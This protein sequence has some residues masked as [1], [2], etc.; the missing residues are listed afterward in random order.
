MGL[1]ESALSW[2]GVGVGSDPDRG[3]AA[4]IVDVVAY[5]E[6]NLI[7]D[8]AGAW[9][10]GWRLRNVT[11]DLLSVSAKKEVFQAFD[12]A[13]SA[14]RGRAKILSLVRDF[15][16]ED[17][18]RRLKEEP[19]RRLKNSPERYARWLSYTDRVADRIAHRRP[20]ERDI[21]VFVQ[22]NP[23]DAPLI[24]AGRRLWNEPSQAA[25]RISG[26]LGFTAADLERAYERAQQIED[27]WAPLMA[28]SPRLVPHDVKHLIARAPYRAIGGEPPVLDGWRP[29]LYEHQSVDGEG[30]LIPYY[31][32]DRTQT[33]H[34]IGDVDWEAEHSQLAFYHGDGRVG[35]Q[36]FL[37]ISRMP[38]EGLGF[39]GC[40]YAFLSQA[41][42]VCLD[43]DV[44]GPEQAEQERKGK[45]RG[46][47]AQAEHQM[48]SGGEVGLRLKEGARAGK[49]LEADLAAGRPQVKLHATVAVAAPTIKELNRRA[50]AVTGDLK[51]QMQI[52]LSRCMCSQLEAFADTLPCG[53]RRQPDYVQHVPTRTV[54]GSTPVGDSVVGHRDGAYLGITRQTGG[55]VGLSPDLPILK[56]MS[57]A[58]IFCGALGAGKSV[59]FYGGIVAPQVLRGH[60]AMIVDPKGDAKNLLRIPEIADLTRLVEV[61][62]GSDARLPLHRIFPVSEI[63]KTYDLLETVLME[64]FGVR[65][66]THPM[67]LAVKFAAKKWADNF[68]DTG[69]RTTLSYLKDCFGAVAK[70]YRQ[71]P[72]LSTAARLA[73]QLTDTYVGHP[74]AGL[75]F[76]DEVGSSEVLG[77]DRDEHP[78]NIIYADLP[79]PD[80][81]EI[82]SGQMNESARL[83]QAILGVVNAAAVQMVSSH[84]NSR[85]KRFKLFGSDEA[86]R[87][88]AN[89][90][91]RRHNQNVTREGRSRFVAPWYMTQR[92]SDVPAEI[93]SQTKLRFIGRND[94]EEDVRAALS[95]MRVDVDDDLVRLVSSFE[96]GNFIFQDE[97]GN[98]APVYFDLDPAWLEILSSTPEEEDSR[99]ERP[100]GAD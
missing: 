31:R 13:I 64:V 85:Y 80:R 1:T 81:D 94:D 17:Y 43:F 50:K 9:W 84:K 79:L 67:Y 66:Q 14:H 48:E 82:R 34:L 6:E 33:R 58:G 10:A 54:A 28:D 95:D 83:G 38:T 92:Y 55:L 100:S 44:I 98:T 73:A 76:T 8:A 52:E 2:A 56:N 59:N 41:V 23:S 75:I 70:E 29:S 96:S 37:K 57:G 24:S 68:A 22:L 93:R 45:A 36:R 46:L 42:D 16:R 51:S 63:E 20:T 21:Y 47:E 61:A 15:D 91:G 97:R 78:L 19:R 88:F 60:E 77:S 72:D 12:R 62:I 11:W 71:N 49:L 53:P 3:E 25:R 39:P 26:K 69:G 86:W 74:L 18:V 99:Q 27:E 65:E 40:E 90:V 89:P 7:W 5:L 87:H 4:S 32:P 30:R 35:F